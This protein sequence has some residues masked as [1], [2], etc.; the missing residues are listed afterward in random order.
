MY[1]NGSVGYTASVHHSTAPLNS[2]HPDLH[3]DGI[4]HYCKTLLGEGCFRPR[5]ARRDHIQEQKWDICCSAWMICTTSL[6]S[7]SGTRTSSRS[8]SLVF[9]AWSNVGNGAREERA[10]SSPY[11]TDVS[12]PRRKR[13]RRGPKICS[14]PESILISNERVSS[15]QQGDDSVPSATL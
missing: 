10:N 8:L 9:G 13:L 12:L 7:I 5:R 3:C 1:R 2:L 14:Y 11:R 15:Y 4:R 6:P